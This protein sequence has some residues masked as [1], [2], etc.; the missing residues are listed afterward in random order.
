MDKIFF[1]SLGC[2]KNLVDSEQMIGALAHRGYVFTED[3]NEA[4]AIIVNSCCFIGDAKEESINRIIELGALK[5][6]GR[7]RALIVCGCLAQ[8]YAKEIREEL[9]EVDALVGT[10]AFDEILEAV[11]EALKGKGIDHIRDINRLS[12]MPDYRAVTT[13]GHYAYLKIADGCDKRCTYCVIPHIRGS[14]R[15]VP[16][17]KLVDE[18]KALVE[19]G[20][21]ELIIVAQET[22]VYGTDL[23]GKKS[24]PLL[25]KKLCAIDGLV[26]IRLLYCYPEE[27]D[28]ELIEVIKSEKK[29]C[30]YL[31]LPIQS[32][33]DDILR[34]MGR[35]TNS[36]EIKEL[37]N[38]LRRE[39]P[40]IVLRT[41]LIT[42]FP[43]ETDEN[44][45]ETL[46]FIDEL[47]FDRL[48]AFKYSA[49]E[50]TYAAGLPEQVSDEVMEDRLA[51]IMELQQEIAFEKAEKKKNQ[52]LLVMIEGKAV[53]E[54]VYVAR[55]YMDAPGV[56]GLVFVQTDAEL[57]TGD[58]VPVIVSG[59]YEYDLIAEIA[60]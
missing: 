45:E 29:I 51:E 9:Y 41:T 49:E 1:V 26:W 37:V 53:D 46:E 39:I 42:G 60:E 11:D 7:L 58:F 31:D 16:M 44:H 15:S 38:K 34:R 21:K 57:M 28:D 5:E 23:Y 32:G 27:I 36:A 33:S 47:E 19:Q 18:A 48:G 20:V 25:L 30:K 13:G 50:G 59:A 2:D 43:G 24:L 35:R 3:E 10:T 17:E 56:D 4:D 6:S 40:D 14:F 55:S 52:K 12:Y 54:E 8:R 22:T